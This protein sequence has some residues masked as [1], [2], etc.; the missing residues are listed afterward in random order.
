MKEFYD[1]NGKEVSLEQLVRNEPEWAANI[2]RWY[3]NK[4]IVGEWETGEPLHEGDYLVYCIGWF[5]P[6]LAEFIEDEGEGGWYY[7]NRT[8]SNAPIPDYYA[9]INLPKE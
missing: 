4:N 7:P 6:E 1:I 9:K 2:I 8:T 3:K 5:S